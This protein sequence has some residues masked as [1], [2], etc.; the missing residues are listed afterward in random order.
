MTNMQLEIMVTRSTLE[1]LFKSVW[2]SLSEKERRLFA[3]NE[4]KKWGYG[5]IS[6]VSEICKLS[7]TT[8]SK[9]L[10]EL[11][12]PRVEDG[13]I[14]RPG[15]GRPK[16][17]TFDQELPGYLA[18]ILE[19]GELYSDG[20]RMPLSWTLKSTRNLA[21]ELSEANHPLSYVKVGQLLKELGFSLKSKKKIKKPKGE[22]ERSHQYEL[23]NQETIRS[24]ETK[25]PVLYLTRSHVKRRAKDQAGFSPLSE[26]TSLTDLLVNF[27]SNWWKEGVSTTNP[28]VESMLVIVN[29]SSNV[30][31]KVEEKMQLDL[32]ELKGMLSMKTN[33]LDF[34]VGTHRWN[35]KLTELF[36]CLVDYKD[37]LYQEDLETKI[38]LLSW[39]EPEKS[40]LPLRYHLHL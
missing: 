16:L 6:L 31:A 19:M 30:S 10:K 28:A 27:L 36:T 38:Y 18:S 37:S 22:P 24:L 25:E 8:I 34:P 13:R 5:G 39:D 9:G 23:I 20:V 40:P 2:P 12:E 35:L 4:A 7:R 1:E 26:N 15:A 11:K 3:A 29:D 32:S 14:R 21:K 33:F 17:L